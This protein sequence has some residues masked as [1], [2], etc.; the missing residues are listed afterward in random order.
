MGNRR[1]HYSRTCGEPEEVMPV[2]KRDN[3]ARAHVSL[4]SG[5]RVLQVSKSQALR[6]AKIVL[7]GMTAHTARSRPIERLLALFVAAMGRKAPYR[8]NEPERG[9]GSQP[10]KPRARIGL[11]MHLAFLRTDDHVDAR[12]TVFN[13][14]RS[15]I[16]SQ[17]FGG[18]ER[19]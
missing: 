4:E 3:L 10:I 1:Q 9:E 18:M 11:Q 8:A 6:Q 13:Q 16:P 17:V 7:V 14:W 2:E 5:R 19:S 15:A 12:R